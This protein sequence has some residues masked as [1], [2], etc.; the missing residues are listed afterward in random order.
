MPKSDLVKYKWAKM[1]SFFQS[2]KSVRCT[3]VPSVWRVARLQPATSK[4]HKFGLLSMNESLYMPKSDLVKYKW[5]KME[6]F[7]Q[8]PKSVRRTEVPSVWRIAR[9]QPATSNQ[10]V[11]VSS[12]LWNIAQ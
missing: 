3:E 10:F 12:K 1:E 11:Y 9:S 7:F 4:I 5:A 8:S 6:S 2:P